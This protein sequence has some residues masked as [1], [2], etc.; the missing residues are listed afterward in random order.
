[1]TRA[2]P[3]LLITLLASLLAACSGPQVTVRE[4]PAPRHEKDRAPAA[5][6]R[7]LDQV[8]DASP[9]AEPRSRYGNPAS[10]EVYGV[11]YE[12]RDRPAGHT[13]RGIASWYGEK[14]HGRRTSSG[15]PYD[16]YAM[17]AAHK[18]LPLPSYVEVRHLNNDRRI[19]VKVN[20]RGPFA[21]GRIIDLSY[22]AAHKLGIL[23]QGT[24][25]VEIRVLAAPPPGAAPRGANVSYYVQA[26]AF[27]EHTNARRLRQR[28]QGRFTVPVE[29]H[30]SGQ[31]AGAV[32][33][34]RLG[35]LQDL[36][37]VERLRAQLREQGLATTTVSTLEESGHSRP[38]AHDQRED[39]AP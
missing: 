29:I 34:V 28:L 24:A 18:T 10:Y 39:E 11:R 13:E 12:V 16:M 7:N 8:P 20:D 27:G 30:S 14:F 35:P 2:T 37:A 36:A 31:T 21:E 22:T 33:R 23:R 15:E 25:P 3:L 26:G 1:M 17:T 32:H 9:R 19:V 5:P 4:G 38:A 6:P